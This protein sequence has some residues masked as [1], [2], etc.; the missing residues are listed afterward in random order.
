MFDLRLK[1]LVDT[2]RSFTKGSSV[3][4]L[5]RR[6]WLKQRVDVLKSLGNINDLFA[7]C[8]KEVVCADLSVQEYQ[9]RLKELD[10]LLGR[11]E[12]DGHE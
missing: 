1:G 4:E 5:Q 12:R 7:F 2:W 9:E 11:V 3:A 6:D 8:S 10:I